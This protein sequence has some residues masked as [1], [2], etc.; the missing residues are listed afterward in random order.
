MEGDKTMTYKAIVERMVEIEA[1]KFVEKTL[2]LNNIK[3]N[4]AE[5]W[6][7]KMEN[8]KKA[9]TIFWEVLVKIYDGTYFPKKV[10]VGGTADSH[11]MICSSVIWDETKKNILW[12]ATREARNDLGITEMKIA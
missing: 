10:L 8:D 6:E 2:E 11:C 5:A 12:M 7:T 3:Y 9:D 4:F 1:T